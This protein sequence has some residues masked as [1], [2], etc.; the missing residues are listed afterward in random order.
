[1]PA[2]DP[3]SEG[4]VKD[5]SLSKD[6]LE[7]VTLWMLS[8]TQ[9]GTDNA[10]KPAI[11]AEKYQASNAPA[12]AATPTAPATSQAPTEVASTTAPPMPTAESAAP[13]SAPAQ[14]PT[15]R[16][17]KAVVAKLPHTGSDMP[18]VWLL[19]AMALAGAIVLRIRRSVLTANR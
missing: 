12:V 15:P 8:S 18:L 11:A 4:K 9:V 3:A 10:K 17:H 14:A 16:V 7:V 5:A 19:G 1:M 2:I 6:D 13:V